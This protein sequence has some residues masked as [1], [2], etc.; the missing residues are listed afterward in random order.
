[1]SSERGYRVAVVGA[2]GVVGRELTTLLP[3][4]DF[5]IAEL[6]LY[7]AEAE[8]GEEIEVGG[9]WQRVERLPNELPEVDVA[10]LCATAE[11]SREIAE[12]LAESGALVIDLASGSESAPLVLGA[13]DVGEAPRT[14]RGGMV[15]RLPD[16]LTRLVG[17]PLRAVAALARVERA[18]VTG[19]VSASAFGRAELDRL[20]QA[21]VGVLNFRQPEEEQEEESDG[22]AAPAGVAFRCI[23]EDPT[24]PGIASRVT[25]ELG[26]LLVPPLP[27]AVNV[28]RAPFFYGHAA[29]L[30]IE[31]SSPVAIDRVRAV[32]RDAPS[33][34]VGEGGASDFSTLDAVGADAIYVVGLAQR[35]ADPKWVHW[36]VLSDN[37]RQGAALAAVSIAEGLAVRH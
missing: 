15:V 8:E 2:T 18:I 4:R 23:P 26:Q 32:L 16:P 34:V 3:E 1:V 19:V 33:L 14:A 11:V 25:A 29:S 12:E 36:W 17:V 35:A 22:E 24:A 30:S 5:P 27:V 10:F 13:A 20:S 9:D 21:T 7:A 6:R 31:L 37:I 28:V